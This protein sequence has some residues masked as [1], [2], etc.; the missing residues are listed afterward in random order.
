MMNKHFFS[1]GLFFLGTVLA[2]C[3]TVSVNSDYDSKAD[4]SKYKTYAWE[5]EDQPRAG[6]PRLDNTLIDSRVRDAV[7]QTL[8]SKGFQKVSSGAPDFIVAYQA[9]IEQKMD[10]T[11]M[12]TPYYTPYATGMAYGG[13][14]MYSSWNMH[15]GTDTFVTQYDEGTLF[16]DIVDPKTNALIWRGTGKKAIDENASSAKRESNINKA[17]QKILS[18]FPPVSRS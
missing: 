1:V 16:V 2:G 12:T 11:Q 4:F 15:G 8:S 7:D 5:S 10:V 9:A 14:S 17:V 13:A 18:E 6:D 3:A